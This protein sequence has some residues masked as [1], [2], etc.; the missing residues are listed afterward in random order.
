MG[1]NRKRCSKEYIA[2]L[3]GKNFKIR[4]VKIKGYRGTMGNIRKTVLRENCSCTFQ[5]F[6]INVLLRWKNDTPI[7]GLNITSNTIEKFTNLYNDTN[8]RLTKTDKSWEKPWKKV[9]CLWNK[10]RGLVLQRKIKAWSP[11]NHSC[12]K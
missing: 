10:T 8:K 11:N 9:E 4:A 6:A 2:V 12:H 7:L 3:P 5:Y 1:V